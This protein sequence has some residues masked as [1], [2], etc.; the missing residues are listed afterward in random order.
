MWKRFLEGVFARPSS[1]SHNRRPRRNRG[2]SLEV[3]ED[4]LTP[5]GFAISAGGLGKD[6]GEAVAAGPHGAVYVAGKFLMTSP[7]APSGAFVAKYAPGGWIQHIHGDT[8]DNATAIAVD[9]K[10]NAYVTGVFRGMADFGNG[11]TLTSASS[12]IYNGF[13]EKLDTNGNVLWVTEIASPVG[14][15][16]YGIAL[17]GH[18]NVYTTGSLNSSADILGHHL[19]NPMNTSQGTSF[20]LKQDTLGNFIWVQQFGIPDP[21]SSYGDLSSANAIAVNSAGSAIYV[22]GAFRG[23]NVQ[24]GT[25]VN[26]PHSLSAKGT[27]DI[28]AEKFDALG[29][30]VWAVRAGSTTIL[31]GSP[32]SANGIALDSNGTP[33]ITGSFD[34]TSDFGNL[35]LTGGNEP[36]TF[37]AKLDPTN[38]DFLEAVAFADAGL[39]V[40]TAIAADQMGNLYA[41]GFFENTAT[42]G[43]L[44]LTT[45]G[46]SDVYVAKLDA[47]LNVLCVTQLGG[48]G[49]DR[50]FGVA[51]D[52]L[53]F[54]DVTGSFNQS[55]KFLNNPPVTL[56]SAGDTDVFVTRMRM[57]CSPTHVSVLDLRLQGDTANPFVITDDRHWGINVAQ[58]NPATVALH[59]DPFRPNPVKVSMGDPNELDDIRASIVLGGPDSDSLDLM[60]HHLHHARS[61]HSGGGT[62]F[63]DPEY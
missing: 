49:R 11:Q 37:V 17:D 35:Q 63:H 42:F 6:G 54:V 46:D 52:K 22:G 30:T 20:L 13:I 34:N 8:T 56:T 33:T 3:L 31:E 45:R 14:A 26:T 28:F 50:G 40:G 47:N 59:D 12:T 25:N 60:L 36:N 15:G 19:Q 48:E 53:G 27:T 4:R 57:D 38:G 9:A 58:G 10:G 21:T 29:N 1:S 55:G 44:H 2:L 24:F 23:G 43:P 61:K 16:G 62:N 51:V 41:T 39:E 32:E 18:A 5:S 7:D